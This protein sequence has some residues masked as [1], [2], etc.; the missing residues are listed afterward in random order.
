MQVN[1]SGE[2]CL[3][4]LSELL[5]HDNREPTLVSIMWANNETGVIQPI[6]EVALLCRQNNA[7]FHV[8]ATQCVG[9]IPIQLDTSC[10]SSISFSAH[11]FHGPP[12]V[13]ALWLAPG[14][15]LEPIMFGGEQQLESRPGTEPVA[16]ISGMGEAIDIACKNMPQT[17]S[18]CKSLRNHLENSLLKCFSS[19]VIQGIDSLEF[20]AQAVFPS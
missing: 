1:R 12:G 18:H 7:K 17:D 2:V 20:P 6:D 19:L 14:E 3:E 8:D 9:K 16:L 13:G 10:L 5:K 4:N 15:S 11:K